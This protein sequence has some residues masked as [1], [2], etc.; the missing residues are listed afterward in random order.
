MFFL[1]NLNNWSVIVSDLYEVLYFLIWS[2]ED[3]IMGFKVR[4]CWA[5][6]QI[7]EWKCVPTSTEH[8]KHFIW[9]LK[10]NFE[11][12]LDDVVSFSKSYH[13]VLAKLI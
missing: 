7:Q 11:E 1:W 4:G 2:V 8:K 12:N 9:I 5:A 6:N 13:L 10:M 3:K